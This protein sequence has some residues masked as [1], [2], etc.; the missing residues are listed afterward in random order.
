MGETELCTMALVLSH[1]VQMCGCRSLLPEEQQSQHRALRAG[2]RKVR[3]EHSTSVEPSHLRLGSVNTAPLSFSSI[4]DS[5]E[6]ESRN[7]PHGTKC[8]LMFAKDMLG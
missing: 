4:P 8:P 1:G 5:T 3:L 7:H 6:A 2:G